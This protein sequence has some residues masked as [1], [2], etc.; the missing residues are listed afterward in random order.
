MTTYPIV[1]VVGRCPSNMAGTPAAMIERTGH[2]HE[3]HEP[4]RHVVA[5]VGGREPREVHPGPPDGEEHH[6]V[7]GESVCDVTLGDG[8]VQRRG[9]LGDRDDEHQVEEQLER[10]GRAMRLVGRSGGHA[11][12]YQGAAG[13]RRREDEGECEDIGAGS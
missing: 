13:P 1:T 2:L 3:H 7:A 6:Q 11:D 12:V 5:V 4:V 9:G 8:V 10:R